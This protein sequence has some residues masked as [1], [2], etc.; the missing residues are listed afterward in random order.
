MQVDSLCHTECRPVAACACCFY[1]LLL[2]GGSTNCHNALYARPHSWQ[3]P[4]RSS[5]IPSVLS[6]L[7]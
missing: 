3:L 5:H 4:Q 6:E 2:S 1:L 7:Q